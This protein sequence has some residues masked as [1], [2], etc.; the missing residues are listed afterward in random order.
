MR[1]NCTHGRRS[2]RLK[3]YDYSKNGLY[4]VTIC[5][6][7]REKIFGEII[8]GNMKLNDIGEMLNFFYLNLQNRYWNMKC[9][10]YVIM[11]N[12][13]HFIIEIV[14][15]IMDGESYIMQL[16]EKLQNKNIMEQPCDK[17]T[18][19][20]PQGIAPTLGDIVGGFK[21][22]TTVKYIENIKF[23]NWKPFDGKIWQRNYYE[24]II[25]DEKDY[26]RISDYIKNNP[27]NWKED[28]FNK[29]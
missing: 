20:Q 27:R 9:H 28:R 3:N 4:F 16:K 21:S 22:L 10:E 26:A 8:H 12:H 19:G 1:D 5:T 14:N 18:K 11:P 6:Q 13:I 24:H 15:E 7:N 2:I 29:R 17:K 23:K 25:R